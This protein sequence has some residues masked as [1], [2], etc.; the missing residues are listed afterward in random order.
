MIKYGSVCSGIEAATVAWDPL[1]WE[2]QWFCEIEPFPKKVLATRF[3]STPD[4]DN[5]TEV[6]GKPEFQKR[7]IDLLVGGT[8]CQS[9]SQAGHRL[10]LGDPRGNLALHF[11]KIAQTKQP[12]WIVWENVPGVL[13]SGDGA[14]FAAILQTMVDCGYGVCWRM[15]DAQY[16]GLPQRRKRIFVV[17]HSGGDW[18]RAA[19]VLFERQTSCD[20]STGSAQTEGC[21]PVCTVRNAGNANARGVVVAENLA[22]KGESNNAGFGY[23][24]KNLYLRRLTPAEEERRMGFSGD[25]TAIEGAADADRYKAIGNSMAVPVMRWIGEGIQAVDSIPLGGNM[26]IRYT[27]QQK[28]EVAEEVKAGK[29]NKDIVAKTGVQTSTVSAVRRSLSVSS[30]RTTLVTTESPEA[31][32]RA[33]AQKYPEAAMYL[34]K[35]GKVGLVLP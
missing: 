17:G 9:F 2:S 32:A 12:S 5:M 1:G 11:L 26:A 24:G 23:E 4:L 13:S 22:C 3:P 29:S 7:D 33:F 20:N 27:D 21:I 35:H 28:Q 8:P 6:Y 15:L 19:A 30:P 34:V 10:G 25:H 31:R 18:R 16:F 14:D